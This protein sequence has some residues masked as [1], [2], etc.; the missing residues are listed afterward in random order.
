M[1][2]TPASLVVFVDFFDGVVDI[3]QGVVIDPRH[4]RCRLFDVDQPRGGDRIETAGVAES[5]RPQE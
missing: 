5:E 4:D 1:P 3:D 2:V